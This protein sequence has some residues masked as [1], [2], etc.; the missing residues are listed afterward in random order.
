MS[1]NTITIVGNLGADVE[2][3]NTNNGTTFYRLSV[4]TTETWKD[5]Q[6]NEK[7]SHTTW[8]KCMLYGNYGNLTQYLRKGQCVAITGT[9]RNDVIDYK[10]NG[11]VV[12]FDGKPIKTSYPFIKVDQIRLVGG[13]GQSDGQAQPSTAQAPA[14]TA[15]A[16]TAQAATSQHQNPTTP[17]PDDDLPF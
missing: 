7:K 15:Q 5:K 9:Q 13:S 1:L 11:Q 8:H 3:I 6:T 16:A 2:V 14:A 17:E 10:S 12:M 4:A